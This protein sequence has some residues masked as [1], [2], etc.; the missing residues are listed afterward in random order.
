ME[1]M[2][3]DGVIDTDVKPLSKEQIIK[4]RQAFNPQPMEAVDGDIVPDPAGNINNM[5]DKLEKALAEMK[6]PPVAEPAK[7]EEPK[8]PEAKTVEKTVESKAVDDVESKIITSAK[9]ADWK[10]IKDAKA[11]AEA[12]AAEFEQKHNLVAK[13]YEE[14]RKKAVDVAKADELSKSL[15]AVEDERNRYR[16]ELETVAL[17]RSETFTKQ[18]KTRYDDA[19]NRATEAVG[20]EDSDKIQQLM[21]LPPSKW[22]K[23]RINEIREKLEGV[24]Q[25]Q[26]DIA[27]ADYDRT[28]NDRTEMLKNSKENYQRLV[29]VESER[30]NREKELRLQQLKASAAAV[31]AMARDKYEAFKAGETEESKTRAEV[32]ADK[33][34]RFFL[35]QL[36][37]EELRDLPI[38]AA[39]ADRLAEVVEAL[40]KELTEAKETLKKY[41][42]S[43]PK[44]SGD[45]RTAGV[46][47]NESSGD[48][49]GDAQGPSPFI[50]KFNEHW[51]HG[52]R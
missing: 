21:A 47:G 7:V 18:F 17:E 43:S 34:Q 50:N 25:G 28:T 16:Q 8:K 20:K 19:L 48:A 14:F 45:K 13:E 32:N 30:S 31:L 38:K 5:A 33:L 37:G 41:Q 1:T 2:T 12:K 42:G 36:K 27:I 6:N 15:K 10:A 24:D 4:E 44:A 3:D 39:E 40:N 26:L 11:K 35:G 49:S 29:G 46:I 9:A 52:N 22:R 51:P 23:E